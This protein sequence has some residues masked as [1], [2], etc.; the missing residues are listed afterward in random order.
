MNETIAEYARIV[1]VVISFTAMCF[2]IFGGTWFSYLGNTFKNVENTI[3]EERQTEVQ[4]Q[5]AERR[6]PTLDVQG[7]TYKVGET[8]PVR[9][10]VTSA[11]TIGPSGIEEDIA[12]DVKIFCDH[13]NYDPEKETLI[14]LESGSYEVVYTVK[15]YLG[16]TTTKRITFIATA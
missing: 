9:K 14:L 4:E 13:P 6:Q 11:K 5:I 3:V 12:K 8:I 7:A 2:F 10:A 15:D 1:I 16:V